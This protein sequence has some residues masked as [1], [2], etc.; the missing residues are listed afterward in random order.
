MET[1][2]QFG[3]D[4]TP[5]LTTLGP[6]VDPGRAGT[7][8][9][10]GDPVWILPTQLVQRMCEDLDV[11]HERLEPHLLHT[12]EVNSTNISLITRP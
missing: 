11:R 10:K 4:W 12:A 2:T 1:T 9:P 8:Y 6:Q 7:G 5:A 3:T